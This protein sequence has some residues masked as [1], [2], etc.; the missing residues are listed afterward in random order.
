MK[1]AWI[2]VLV[3]FGF[4][5]EVNSSAQSDKFVIG[6]WNP[7]WSPAQSSVLSRVD[8]VAVAF[9]LV[10]PD[11]KV[12]IPEN[13][14]KDSIMKAKGKEVLVSFGGAVFPSGEEIAPAFAKATITRENR[15]AVAKEMISKSIGK[16]AS[17][18]ELDWEDWWESSPTGTQPIREQFVGLVGEIAKQLPKNKILQ[19]ALTS[20]VSGCKPYVVNRAQLQLFQSLNS[21]VKNI[22]KSFRFTIMH[23]SLQEKGCKDSF[24]PLGAI[25]PMVIALKSIGIDPGNLILGLPTYASS[26]TRGESG[27]DAVLGK[28]GWYY[29][30]ANQTEFKIELAKSLGLYGVYFW[31]LDM[32]PHR[33]VKALK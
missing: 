18:L 13:T 12:E 27:I 31:R 23:Y 4:T 19:V 24:A 17:G 28:P 20:P 30:T 21:A 6:G 9:G 14:L 3:V 7:Q 33:I 25:K 5:F 10:Y 11:G 1:V 29:D 26:E 32:Q 16:G 15:I 2:A 22:G 8:S